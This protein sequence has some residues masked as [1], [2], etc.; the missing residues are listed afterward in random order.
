M[1]VKPNEELQPS[2][3]R[4][5][6]VPDSVLQG[7]DF[8]IHMLWD[9]ERSV[10]IDVS[11]PLDLVELKEVYN[12]SKTA[13]K[14]EMER[15]LVRV[16]GF[17]SNGYVGFV[18][19]SR[20]FEKTFLEVPIRI[21]VNDNNTGEKQV[22]ERKISFFRP[23]VVLY[24]V[25]TYIELVG[26]S[27]G[28]YKIPMNKKIRLKNEGKGTALVKFEIS[29]ESNVV[30]RKPVEVEEFIE[31][32]CSRLSNKL[33][34]LRNVYPQYTDVINGFEAFLLD[35][36]KGTFTISKEYV[37]RVQE[38]LD[39]LE[40]AFEESEDFARDIAEAILSAYLSAINV[41]TEIRS[42]LEYLKSLASN[43]VILLNAM[44]MM[45]F[46][47]GLNRLKGHLLFQDLAGNVY[48]PIEIQTCVEVK[49]NESIMVPLYEIFEWEA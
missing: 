41:L 16:T 28:E 36:I 38:M 19:F 37:K 25:P 2:I 10:S 22:I 13:L 18:F 47:P 4:S 7:T 49:S 21:E 5:F 29:K 34:S 31:T 20:V 42:F 32:F 39:A 35:L 23:H 12:V 27:E 40:K 15:N 9:K 46:K 8:S 48:N 3:V 17:E 6:F 11:L 14:I 43:R 24:E 44:S 45:E 26:G 1:N 33:S 30:I